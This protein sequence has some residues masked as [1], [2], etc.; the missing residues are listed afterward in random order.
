[1]LIGV[2]PADKKNERDWWMRDYQLCK[3]QENVISCSDTCS[4]YATNVNFQDVKI[5][6][7]THCL[8]HALKRISVVPVTL[9]KQISAYWRKPFPES[10]ERLSI[11][12]SSGYTDTITGA[13]LCLGEGW[14]L[15]VMATKLTI[16]IRQM[17]TKI[18]NNFDIKLGLLYAWTRYP[19]SIQL[20][21]P[22]HDFK[23]TKIQIN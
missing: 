16:T 21:L 3:T 17:Q 10:P 12:I 6:Y 5:S 4:S 18:S 1:M 8:H 7:E 20:T 22:R 19:Y 14:Q 15:N 9:T 13:P 2:T 11:G 23:V